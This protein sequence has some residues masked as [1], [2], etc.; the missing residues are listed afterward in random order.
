MLYE[1]GV[2]FILF[3]ILYYMKSLIILLILST[4]V[5]AKV[6]IHIENKN[7]KNGHTFAVLLFSDKKLHLAP[8]VIFKKKT[9]QMFSSNNS[10]KKYEVFIPID[11]YTKKQQYPV[12]VF[13][14]NDGK[15]VLKTFYINVIDGQ[16]KTNEIIKVKK[17]KVTL[18]KKNKTKTSNEYN[19]VFKN[20]YSK[21][22]PKN[23]ILNSEFIKPIQ[24]KITSDF[25]TARVY[26]E[27]VK[28][29]HTG[30]DF[31]A[32]VATKIYASNDGVI[33][34]VMKRFYLGNVVYINHGRGAYS[35]YSH[36]S[37][38]I[39]KKAQ[40]IKKGDLLGF[41]GKTG[42]VTAPHLHYAFRLYNVTVDPLQ[43]MN[44]HNE[45]INKYEF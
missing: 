29:Y 21:I 3:I 44:L 1:K 15:K 20:V 25:G 16:Y 13:Y 14:T 18:S 5:F 43:Y 24:S 22:S 37:K 30:V 33:A 36:M 41:S 23:Y 12:K 19:T 2:Y 45:L 40:R 4:F 10:D 32:K 17:S 9:Y 28:S 8:N 35:Y 39:V 42:R 27:L 7:V 34:L 11:Y 31:R 6:T 26:N 38:I